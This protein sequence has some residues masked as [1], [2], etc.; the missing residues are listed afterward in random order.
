M[1]AGIPGEQGREEGAQPVAVSSVSNYCAEKG[2]C[3][4]TGCRL[5]MK[6]AKWQGIVDWKEDD[7]A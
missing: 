1:S 5:P 7:D 4:M 3:R 6:T 2:D